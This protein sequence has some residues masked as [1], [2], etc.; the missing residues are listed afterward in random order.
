M[1]L[2]TAIQHLCD[3]CVDFVVIGGWAAIFHGSAHV[4]SDLDICYSRDKEN[5]R[6]LA[7]A[8]APY[9]PRSASSTFWPK[10]PELGPTATCV[11]RLWWST[12]LT[13]ESP[14]WIFE[15]KER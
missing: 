8:L 14:H 2:E 12:C 5:L 15:P 7:A 6:K 9:H 10:S 11:L 3:A 1:N 13:G 4:T